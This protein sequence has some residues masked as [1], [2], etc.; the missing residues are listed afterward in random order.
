[1]TPVD[2]AP[3][4]VWC[5]QNPL[6]CSVQNLIWSLSGV[7]LKLQLNLRTHFD[8]K[9]ELCVLS[10]V[11]TGGLRQPTTVAVYLQ[12]CECCAK[13]DLERRVNL[14]FEAHDHSTVET[15][16]PAALSLF[17]L[18]LSLFFNFQ[19]T[20]PVFQQ[21]VP[22]FCFFCFVFNKLIFCVSFMTAAPR[23]LASNPHFYGNDSTNN[24]WG[25]T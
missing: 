21:I 4:G 19:L 7:N 8:I 16:R 10:P 12:A 20:S 9:W 14:S 6:S 22:L 24:T 18:R 5:D 15:S 2:S 25:A 1:M 3:R 23:G 11:W 17:N 13:I